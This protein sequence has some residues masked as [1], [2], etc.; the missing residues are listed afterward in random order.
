MKK[1]IDFMGPFRAR[2]DGAAYVLSV[3]MVKD[4]K[5]S[6]QIVEKIDAFE[7]ELGRNY[8]CNLLIRMGNY[9]AFGTELEKVSWKEEEKYCRQNGKEWG[10]IK[11]NEKGDYILARA[12]YLSRKENL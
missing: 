4:N 8:A 2:K 11:S 12:C 9:I 10:Y 3:V 7:G 5:R 1:N 6:E